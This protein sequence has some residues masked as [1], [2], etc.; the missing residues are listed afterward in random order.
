MGPRAT[1]LFALVALATP[2]AADEGHT[3][4]ASGEVERL[5]TVDFPVTCSKAARARFGRAVAL[6]HSFWYEEAEKAFSAVAQADPSCAMA[7][8]G[9][10]M[11]NYHP[12]WAP[13][14]PAELERGRAAAQKAQAAPAK[15]ARERDYIAAVAAFYEGELEYPARKL[16]FERA[17]ERVFTNHAGD[18]EAAIFYALALLGTAPP[19]DKSYAKQRRAGEILNRI[20]SE[21]PEHPGLAHYLIHSFDYPELADQGLPAARAY[22]KIAASSPHALHMPSHIFTRL[23][24]WDDSIDSNLASAATAKRHVEKTRP[25][26]ASFDQLHALDY[27][28]YAYLQQ[29]RDGEAKAAL[30]EALALD[31]FDLPNFAAAY[32]LAAIPARYSLE[33]RQ[34]AEAA[35]LTVRPA[36]IP[37]DKYPFAEAL[38]HFARAIGGARGGD[39]ATA[40]TARARLAELHAE[41][42]AAKDGYWASQLAIQERAAGAWIALAEGRREEA[43]TLMRSAADLE[44]MTEKHPVTPGALLPARELLADMLLEIG[45]AAGALAEYRASLRAAPGRFVSLAGALRAARALGEEAQA[46]E[47]LAKLEELCA[48]S[49]GQRAELDALR[50][51]R[52]AGT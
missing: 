37:W 29:A 16:A 33:R 28:A 39:L 14:T 34:W 6:L 18:R 7:H 10:A 26:H 23:A 41:R 32:A 51:A 52:R 3:H 45:Q 48:K 43:V 47:L 1:F 17:M 9:V 13:P 31:T 27:L 42:V 38:V 46:A 49:D 36:S 12:L 2:V 44:D 21:A 15:T 40:R 24:L 22:S 19:N 4:H 8:W 20:L 35:A 5:G 50:S 25:G 30:D 11:S